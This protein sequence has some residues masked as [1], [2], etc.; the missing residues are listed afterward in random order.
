[1]KKGELEEHD[2]QLFVLLFF[3][4]HAWCMYAPMHMNVML[5]PQGLE[6]VFR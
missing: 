6:I 2:A 4:L 5:A 3:L 1:M